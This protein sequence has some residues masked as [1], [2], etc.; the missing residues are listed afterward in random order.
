MCAED[1]IFSKISN[2]F[3]SI[4]DY[5]GLLPSD[6]DTTLTSIAKDIDFDKVNED[7]KTLGQEY[8]KQAKKAKKEH[9]KKDEKTEVEKKEEKISQTKDEL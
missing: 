2:A 9:I 8:K 5:L 6:S 3:T 1:G 7:L 4:G